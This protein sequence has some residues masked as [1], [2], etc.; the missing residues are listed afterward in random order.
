MRCVES[1]RASQAKYFRDRSPAALR[2]ARAMEARVDALIANFFKNFP[3]E[4][5]HPPQPQKGLFE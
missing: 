5:S 1:M 3:E 4:K 2:D